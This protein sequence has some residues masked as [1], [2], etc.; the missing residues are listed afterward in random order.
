M[1]VASPILLLGAGASIDAGLPNA[2]DLTRRVYDN[3]P[4]H[5]TEERRLYAYVVAKLLTRQS[6]LG[7]SPFEPLNVE[8]VYDALKRFLSRDEDVLA[9]FV[10]SWDAI[11]T[12]PSA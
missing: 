2:Y 3:L 11:T 12:A 5:S 6:R 4:S 1:N 10:Y 9:E 7:N 8:E